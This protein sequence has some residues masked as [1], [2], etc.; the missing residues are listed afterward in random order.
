MPFYQ[1]TPWKDSAYWTASQQPV[2]EVVAPVKVVR[3][4]VVP[5]QVT[6]AA[7][8]PDPRSRKHRVISHLPTRHYP[9]ATARKTPVVARAVEESTSLLVPIYH[10]VS[11]PLKSLASNTASSFAPAALPTY[12]DQQLDLVPGYN[13]KT[14]I[15]DTLPGY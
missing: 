15:K 12:A 2:P 7:R 4:G 13:S 10:V 9:R 11:A 6:V 5:R 8:R 1:V 14:R 3:R